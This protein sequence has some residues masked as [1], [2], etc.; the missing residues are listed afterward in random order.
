[1]LLHLKENKT[2]KNYKANRGHISQ[3]LYDLYENERECNVD[4]RASNPNLIYL[5]LKDSTKL[6]ATVCCFYSV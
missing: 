5:G 1:M 3:S 2:K 4:M 6:M